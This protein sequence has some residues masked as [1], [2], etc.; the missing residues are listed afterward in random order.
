VAGDET[1]TWQR[2]EDD[3]YVL[4]AVAEN[5]DLR[6]KETLREPLGEPLA[7]LEIPAD[8]AEG[9]CDLGWLSAVEDAPLDE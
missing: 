3:W 7:P 8:Y 2:G 5:L 1:L 4:A 9:P 6:W